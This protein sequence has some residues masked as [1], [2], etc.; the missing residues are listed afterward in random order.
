MDLTKKY[1]ERLVI[2][3]LRLKRTLFYG[4]TAQ[5]VESPESSVRG[6]FT[7]TPPSSGASRSSLKIYCYRISVNTAFVNNP[8]AMSPRLPMSMV[9]DHAD[10]ERELVKNKDVDLG[11]ISNR[12]IIYSTSPHHF[13]M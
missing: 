8:Y 12:K 3:N 5:V 11:I 13:Y 10:R 4:F 1:A 2:N 7:L 6:L 9:N